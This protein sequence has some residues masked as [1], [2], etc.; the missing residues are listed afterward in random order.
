M[1]NTPIKFQKDPHKSV[2]GVAYTLSPTIYVAQSRNSYLAQNNS[3]IGPAQSGNR[4][5]VGIAFVVQSGNGNKVG[6]SYI[7]IY[8]KSLF[9][10]TPTYAV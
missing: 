10:C 4:D 8:F 6:I 1:T 2:G 5:K 3:R 9:L 7:A